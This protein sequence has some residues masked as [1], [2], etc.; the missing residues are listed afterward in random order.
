MATTVL[1][2][3]VDACRINDHLDRWPQPVPAH[4]T[5]P[6][7]FHHGLLIDFLPWK[8][9]LFQSLT[10][11]SHRNQALRLPELLLIYVEGVARAQETRGGSGPV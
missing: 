6:E 4:G 11:S 7:S 1:Y 3:D 8:N 10:H 9:N 2:L 5:A